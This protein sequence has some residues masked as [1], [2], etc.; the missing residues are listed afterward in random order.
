MKMQMHLFLVDLQ[1]VYEGGGLWG[2]MYTNS[3]IIKLR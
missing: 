2:L 3:Q 1:L